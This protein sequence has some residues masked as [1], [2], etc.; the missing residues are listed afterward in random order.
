MGY[1]RRVRFSPLPRVFVRSVLALTLLASV[2][3]CN[4]TPPSTAVPYSQVDLIVGTG[5]T[6]A[7]GQT[8]TVD[9]TG[10]MYDSS[11]VDAKGPVFD[12]SIGRGAF[13]FV[14]DKSN[15]IDGWVR[16]VPGMKEGGTRRL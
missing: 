7:V 9:Y 3:A 13:T 4:T 1:H 14:L 10:Y 16:G 15:V 8:L 12:T 6:A 5:A 2:V 11:K